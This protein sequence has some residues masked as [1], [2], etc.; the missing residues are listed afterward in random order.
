MFFLVLIIAFHQA[1]VH[2]CII[3]PTV[4]PMS[5]PT[6]ALKVE[7]IHQAIDEECS[8]GWRRAKMDNVPDVKRLTASLL[9]EENLV[10]DGFGN[11]PLYY[12]LIL[13]TKDGVC[14]AVV[15]F[16]EYSTWE[17][18]VLFLKSLVIPS[19]EMRLPILQTLAKIAVRLDCVRLVWQVSHL[20]I[21]YHS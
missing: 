4:S 17:G 13:E 19:E 7:A 9:T 21:L 6:I 20:Y 1:S 18:R 10:R 16:F 5:P 3:C 14:G 8:N 2:N 15:F 12:S 11:V